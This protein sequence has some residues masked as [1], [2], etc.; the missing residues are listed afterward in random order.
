M[1]DGSARVLY[2]CIP[3]LVV[4]VAGEEDVASKALASKRHLPTV[5][6]H[7]REGLSSGAALMDDALQQA[8]L[9]M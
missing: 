7:E 3:M 4:G 5:A 6:A 1:C 8:H 9:V 2:R